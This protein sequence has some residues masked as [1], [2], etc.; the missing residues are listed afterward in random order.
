MSQEWFYTKDGKTKVGPV[1][2][3]ELQGLAKSGQL[4]PTDMILKQG[5]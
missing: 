4:L 3:A 5:T 1:S 2:S